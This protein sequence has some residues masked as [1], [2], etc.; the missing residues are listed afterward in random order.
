MQSF[1]AGACPTIAIVCCD[2]TI[3]PHANVCTTDPPFNFTSTTSGGVWSGTGITNTSTGTFS[4]S[5]AGVGTY[6]IYYTLPCGRDSITISVNSCTST[7]V[8]RNANGSLT[9]SGGTAPYT[10]SVW[11]STGRTCVGGIVFGTICLGGTWEATY[12]WTV[13]ATGA[14]ATPPAPTDTIKVVDNAGTTITIDNISSVAP[15]SAC[16]L[17]IQSITPTNPTC[18]SSNGSVTV[19]PTLGTTPYHYRWSAGAADTFATVNGLSAGIYRVTVTDAN[20]CTAVDS[21]TLTNS[22]SLTLSTGSSPASC[23]NSTGSAWVTVVGGSGTYTYAWSVPGTTDTLHNL[24]TGNYTVTVTGGGC[25]GTASVSVSSANGV[26]ASLASQINVKCYGASTGAAYINATGGTLPYT[27]TWSASGSTVDSAH[28]LA[29]GLYTVTVKDANNCTSVVTVTITQPTSPLAATD[30]TSPAYCGNST[31]KI[32]VTASGGTAGY[33]YIWSP[34]VS[35]TDSAVNLAANTYQVTVTDGNLCTVTISPVV[36]PAAG[37]TISLVSKQD[38]TCHADSNGKILVAPAGGT[39]P[40]TYTWSPPVSTVDSAI[41]LGQGSY[42]VVVHDANGCTA[43]LSATINQPAAISVSTTTVSA[44]CGVSDGS[45]TAMVTGGIGTLTYQWSVG[46]STIALDSGLAANS[47]TVTV[48]DS[49]HCTAVGTAA[50]SNIGGPTAIVASQTNENCNGGNTGKIVLNVTGGTQPYTYIWS[51]NVSSVD[52]AVGLTATTY[53]VTVHDA[54]S[55]IAVVAATIT[56]PQA[57]SASL[58]SVNADC[59]LNDGWAKI[60][61]SGGTGSYIYLWSVPQSTDSITGLTGG[62][63][64]VTV[65]DSLGCQLTDSVVVGTNSGPAAPVITAGGPITFCQGGSVVLTSS[66]TTG[67]TWSTTATTQSITVSSAGT[68]TVTQTVGG[69]TSPPSA[70]VV[71]TVNPI[72]PAPTIT[73]SGPLSFCLGDSVTL[74]SSAPS[75]NLWSDNETTQSIVVKSS[76][77]YTVTDTAGPCPGPP[78]A[79]VTVTIVSG[80]QPVITPTQLSLC[81]GTGSDTL[82]ATTA[83]ATAYLWS[84]TSTQPSIIITSAGTYRVTVTVN[85]CQ[86]WDSITINAQPLLGPLSLS[87]TSVCVGDLVTLDATTANATSYVWSG[88]INAITPVINVDSQGV[89]NVVVSNSCGSETASAT[90]SSKDCNCQIVMPDAFTPNGDGVNDFFYPDFKC[91]N[92]KYLIMRIFNRWGEKVFETTDLYGQWDGRYRGSMQPPGV[93]VYYAEFVGLQNNVEKT[94]K[95]IGS[96]TL[97]R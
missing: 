1:A 66:V 52:S 82:N 28:N 33:T 27:Y 59:G 76:G 32:N 46:T 11:D 3:C 80:I 41:G 64:Y 90:I 9:V 45:A 2:A 69:C 14:T 94:Y 58:Q 89:Y 40:Y 93:Y 4:P 87:D 77:T 78:S 26:S 19:T 65:T 37:P 79:S 92:P 39:G 53:T 75:G 74:T 86:G 13:F 49:N 35:T 51:P 68:Y 30:I 43:T 38:M 24:P 96:V 8:C 91:D 21:V 88:A 72:A 61:A 18:G 47:Y 97:I 31:G 34:N 70:A 71:V 55:C 12:G 56:Q 42:T 36:S 73:A 95:L 6:T 50:I 17:A 20:S 23:G 10:W 7:I 81:P 54:S 22:G 5:V 62:T 15:C 85:G 16:N 44:N 29:A 67:N 63:Y 57:L 25:S 83:S 60:T 84:T 48:T